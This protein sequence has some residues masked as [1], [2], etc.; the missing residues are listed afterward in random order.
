MHNP[1]LIDVYGVG[2]LYVDFWL[3]KDM[4][5]Y[6]LCQYCKSKADLIQFALIEKENLL[7]LLPFL[8]LKFPIDTPHALLLCVDY[9][10]IFIFNQVVYNFNLSSLF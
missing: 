10:I 2:I 5:V 8:E 3:P 4:D 7:L 6:C 9:P 1:A